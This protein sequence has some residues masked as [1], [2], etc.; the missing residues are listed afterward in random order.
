MNQPRYRYYAEPEERYYEEPPYISYKIRDSHPPRYRQAPPPPPRYYNQHPPRYEREYY[1]KAYKP[2]EYQ[3]PPV[4]KPV[5][6]VNKPIDDGTMSD[7]SGYTDIG[8]RTVNNLANK[9]KQ[10]LTKPTVVEEVVKPIQH[11]TERMVQHERKIPKASKISKISNEGESLGVQQMMEENQRLKA[12]LNR[13]R[14][15]Q[16]GWF[17][18]ERK[19]EINRIHKE[20]GDLKLKNKRLRLENLQLREDNADL[21]NRNNRA[22]MI[23]RSLE[24]L[25]KDQ[26]KKISNF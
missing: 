6:I 16:N 12:D 10:K 13:L 22:K 23:Q 21:V 3:Q 7:F 11:K 5:K 4:Q 17:G 2:V 14:K 26:K 25:S 24:D 20:N 1:E 18:M 19:Y 8:W 15:I 9:N